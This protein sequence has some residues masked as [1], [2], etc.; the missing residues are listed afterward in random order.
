MFQVAA[1]DHYSWNCSIG[2]GSAS[3]RGNLYG[4]GCVL[5]NI[6]VL[7]ARHIWFSI[8]DKHEWPTVLRH[9]GGFRCEVVFESTEYDI[10]VLRAVASID[11]RNSEPFKKY[12]IFSDEHI[13]L[14][15]SVGF[16]SRLH[17]IK[18]D[19]QV[20]FTHFAFATVSLIVPPENDH[21]MQFALSS[22]V[23]Q[24]G[25]SGSPVFRADG[26]IVGVLTG[27]MSFRADFYNL[28]APIHTLPLISPIL[29]LIQQLEAVIKS[30][31]NTKTPF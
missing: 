28:A 5:D 21:A 16:M 6:H 2:G 9:D 14:G 4:I 24:E 29:P 1:T 8:K 7:T 27:G 10:M 18:N 31:R 22:T 15:S 3:S 13:H 11:K 12:P 19:E 23:T 26:S 30:G 17:L 25:F 20:S